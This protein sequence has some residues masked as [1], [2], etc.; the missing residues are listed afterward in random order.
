MYARDYKTFRPNNVYHV[1]NRGNNRQDIFVDKSDY[2]RFFQ[3]IKVVLGIPLEFNSGFI[4]K[5][6]PGIKPFPAGAFSVLAYCLMP[7]HFHL[8]IK[9]NS[10]IGIDK[11]MLKVCTSYA[12]YFNKRHEKI[13]NIFQ[14]T[15]K[16]KSVDNDKYLTYLS[17][18]IHNNPEA[19]LDYEFSSLKDYAGT[20]N[21]N[22]CNQTLILSMFNN[23]K[24]SYIK[25]VLGF[26]QNY[27]SLIRPLLFEE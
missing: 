25:F 15:F 19:P 4:T 21:E 22:F 6:K 17:A 23:D 16:A 2:S 20:R 7:N 12:K 26:S 24:E 14:D 27:Q 8:L 5:R 3:T 9:Q 1:F 10:E 13:G 18:Y 11:F